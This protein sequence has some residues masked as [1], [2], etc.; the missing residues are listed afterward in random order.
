MSNHLAKKTC[1]VAILLA[2]LLSGCNAGGFSLLTTPTPIPTPTSMPSPTP[3]PTPIPVIAVFGGDISR[4]FI[5]G[6]SSYAQGK[7]YKLEVVPGEVDAL[8]RYQPEGAA[9]A[10]VFLKDAGV[11]LPETQIPIYAY[12]ADGQSLPT[13][14]KRLT[15]GDINAAIDTLNLAITYPPHETPVRMIGLFTSHTSHAH[16]LWG[17]AVDAGRVFE[18]AVFVENRTDQPIDEWLAEQFTVYY[19]GMLD[20]VFAETGAL[21]ISALQ[22]LDSLGRDDV[23]VFSAATDTN[24][25]CSLSSVLVAVKGADLYHAGELCC[26]GAQALLYGEEAKSDTILPVLFQFSPEA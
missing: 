5:E 26:E 11:A 19:P 13:N 16:I 8:S 6:V 9:A 21:A 12:A 7:P 3:V 15:Y 10:I 1:T 22:L 17:R 14:I 4:S 24:A 18:K 25:D 20:A 23:E 2:L